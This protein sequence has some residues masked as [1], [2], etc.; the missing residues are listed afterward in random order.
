M[1]S[2][3]NRRARLRSKDSQNKVRYIQDRGTDLIRYQFRI[4]EG[5]KYDVFI[6]MEGMKKMKISGMIAI[7]D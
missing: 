5:G 1:S 4:K 7:N 3:A 2:T 6:E